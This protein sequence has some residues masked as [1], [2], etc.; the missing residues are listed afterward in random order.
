MDPQSA[1]A[2]RGLFFVFVTLLLDV[3]GIAIIIP[4]LP[5][6][7]QE[8]TGTDVGGAAVDGGWLLVV[9]AVMQFLCAPLVG[10]LGDRFGRRPVL[11]ISVFTFALDNLICALAPTLAWLYVGRVLAGVSGGSFST[12]SAF[13]ADVSTDENRAK[14]FG[15]IGIA[16]GVGFI[17]GPVIGGLLGGLGPRVPFYAAAAL[18]FG[19]FLF[20]WFVLPET[21]KK[22]NRRPFD[23]K[24]ANPAGALVQ[25]M[26]YPVVLWTG[27]VFFLFQFAG[28]SHPSVWAF[29]AEYRYGWSERDIGLSLG[30]VGLVTAVVMGVVLPRVVARYGDHRT[31]VI[32]LTFGVLAYLGFALATQTWMVFAV[33]LVTGL[34]GLSDPALRSIASA[35]IP[36]DAQGE[37][38]GAMT[39]LYS[40]AAIT[41]PIVMTQLFGAFTGPAAPVDLPGAPYYAAALVELA[42]LGILVM[43]VRREKRA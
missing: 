26:K 6:Y 19:N 25:M 27:A 3:M 35:Q 39:S 22:E 13:I 11:L 15:L 41:A 1:A 36:P 12:A 9:Y 33:I 20:G 32:G 42:A 40:L 7:L 43:F 34:A 18:A 28:L 8:L 14:N 29:F 24:R 31:A 16:F 10:N 21:L 30:A 17:V 23:W 5:A 4:V 37:L 38:Q 2:R